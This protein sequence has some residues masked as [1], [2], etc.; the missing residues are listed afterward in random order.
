MKVRDNRYSWMKNYAPPGLDIEKEETSWVACMVLATCWCMRF[1]FRYLDYRSQLFEI[2]G[3]RK[4]LIEGAKMPNFEFLTKD[5]FEVF[6]VVLIFCALTIV[7]HYY[8]H[9]QGSKMMYLMRRLPN[10][11]EV[12]LRCFTLPVVAGVITILYMLVLRLLFFAI[13]YWCTP[14]QCLVL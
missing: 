12:H 6:G 8:Y 4:I 5:L 10:K 13:Y 14:I 11:W 2:R 9:Y 1:L 7:Y 3:S